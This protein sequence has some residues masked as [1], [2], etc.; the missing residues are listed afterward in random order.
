MLLIIVLVFQTK[1]GDP[2]LKK[3]EEHVIRSRHHKRRIHETLDSQRHFS[4]ITNSSRQNKFWR[5]NYFTPTRKILAKT[6]PSKENLEGDRWDPFRVK[7]IR[8]FI[9]TTQRIW[10]WWKSWWRRVERTECKTVSH[11]PTRCRNIRRD[12]WKKWKMGSFWKRNNRWI[13]ST[14]RV[15][16]GSGWVRSLTGSERGNPWIG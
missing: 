4:G 2:P 5:Q 6:K 8:L 9:T 7:V 1:S 10:K 16:G 12:P 15:N 14:N 13:G 3:D 11:M